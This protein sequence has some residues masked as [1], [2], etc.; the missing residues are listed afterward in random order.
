MSRRL[1]LLLALLGCRESTAGSGAIIGSVRGQVF[2]VADAMAGTRINGTDTYAD[3]FLA[4]RA[5]L[6]EAASRYWL[7][8]SLHT[9]RIDL[10]EST[11]QGDRA[12]AGPGTY[13]VV[14]IGGPI[15]ARRAYVEARTTDESCALVAS[16]SA[17]ATSGTVTLTGVSNGSY[18]GTFDVTLESGDRLTGSF[19]APDCQAIGGTTDGP[20]A[21]G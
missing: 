1:A 12:P 21:C 6:C 7:R 3:I 14:A 16:Q 15:S 4:D 9:V 19:D 8:K 20:Y 2:S 17:K 5:G 13:T 11:G 10:Y 18:A